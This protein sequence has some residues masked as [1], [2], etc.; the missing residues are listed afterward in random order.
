LPA[1]LAPVDPGKGNRRARSE[2]IDSKRKEA[3]EWLSPLS[4][5]IV[6]LSVLI[7]QP[8]APKAVYRGYEIVVGAD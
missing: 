6:L 2:A 3:A 8:R 1:F 5:R 4:K 7:E